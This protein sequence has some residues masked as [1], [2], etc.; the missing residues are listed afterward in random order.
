MRN[1]FCRRTDLDSEADVEALFVEKLLA[2]LNYPDNRVKRK[3]TLDKIVVS[4]GRT[5]VHYRPDF[6]LLDVR[7]K[8]VVV[9]DAKA[10]S[11]R[12]DDYRYQVGGYAYALN[13]RFRNENPVRYIVVT[14]GIEFV[15]WDWDVEQPILNMSFEDFSEDNPKFLRLRSLLTYGVL[16]VSRVTKD[17]FKFE[18]PELN[19]LIRTFNECHEIIWKKEAYG[20]TD[21]F[22]EFAKLIFVKLR[23]D[24]RIVSMIAEEKTPTAED[25][26]F[27]VGWIQSQIARDISD[28]PVGEILFKNVRDDLETQIKSG[29]KKR[30]FDSGETLALRTD[31]ILQVVAKL[32]NYDLHGIDE[33]LNGRMFETFLK[34][35]CK[36]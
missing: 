12:P 22:Y 30:I 25:F 20:P 33:D 1:L 36:G 15:L 21:A 27:S 4:R 26:N 16:D 5:R 35:N 24:S 7:R 28:N 14:N 18:R 17:V 34:C 32:E 31:T 9:I 11:E 23:E 6:V 2:K 8:P 29:R 19:E 3:D 13:Q 10:P